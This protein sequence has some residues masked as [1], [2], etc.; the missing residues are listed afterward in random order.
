MCAFL[1]CCTRCLRYIC[2]IVDPN[3]GMGMNKWSKCVCMFVFMN[4]WASQTS[5][6][7]GFIDVASIECPGGFLF[8]CALVR[9][10]PTSLPYIMRWWVVIRAL[11]TTT[12]LELAVRSNS[13]SASWGMFT[14]IS[15]V[16]WIRS[17]R[18]K[19]RRTKSYTTAENKEQWWEKLL[20]VW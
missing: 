13:V 5:V 20:K 2:I 8:A 9:E 1:R 3:A 4:V 15:L 7:I 12:Q 10:P 14:F 16:Q 6:I 18:G 11:K 19:K 17:G